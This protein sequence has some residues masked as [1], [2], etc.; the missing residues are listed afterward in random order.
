MRPT[1]WVFTVRKELQKF[2]TKQKVHSAREFVGAPCPLRPAKHMEDDSAQ[3]HAAKNPVNGE[4]SIAETLK[5]KNALT[6]P[7]GSI[8]LLN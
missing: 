1:E 2:K 5:K 6:G 3:E 8:A 7:Q 4:E